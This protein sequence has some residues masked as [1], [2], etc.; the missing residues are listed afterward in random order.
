MSK[1]YKTIT[2]ST[3]NIKFIVDGDSD[4]A[5]QYKWYITPHGYAESTSSVDGKKIH[6]KLHR[7]IIGAKNGQQVDHING[8]KL[9][10]R[11]SNLRI[12][13][14][15]GNSANSKIRRNSKT[16]YKGVHKQTRSGKYEAK[17]MHNQKSIYISQFR[18]GLEA[19]MAYDNAALTLFGSF[20]KLNQDMV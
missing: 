14:R 2:S 4:L 11:K 6:L 15:S 18:T 19:A 17:I 12:C 20:A 9:D 16:G 8:N 10:N 5:T 13:T 1:P 3:K 7:L